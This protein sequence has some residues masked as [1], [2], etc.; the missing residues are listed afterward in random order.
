[1]AEAGP[2]ERIDQPTDVLGE[3]PPVVDRE[4]GRVSSGQRFGVDAGDRHS[5][6]LD[7][8]SVADPPRAGGRRDRHRPAGSATLN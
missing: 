8:Q 2:V 3:P 5:A 1:M 4:R 6:V 7:R